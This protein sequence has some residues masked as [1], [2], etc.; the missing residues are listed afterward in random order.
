M[1]YMESLDQIASQFAAI[2]V[3]FG[4]ELGGPSA[5]VTAADL[6]ASMKPFITL[7]GLNLAALSLRHYL[8][9][10]GLS[11]VELVF[12]VLIFRFL[13]G[14]ILRRRP[15]HD[16]ILRAQ[17]REQRARAQK[18][19]QSEGENSFKS[20]DQLCHGTVFWCFGGELSEDVRKALSTL[21]VHA[22][23]TQCE[24]RKAYLEM[25]KRY[26]PD[27]FAQKPEELEQAQH[28]TL[29]IRQ[30]YDMIAKQ[31]CQAQ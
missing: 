10:I 19:P 29:K 1:S 27:R 6:V 16:Q 15:T 13:F 18:R 23:A 11:L 3:P 22:F 8:L 5:S 20:W 25:M 26:H 24:V 2:L 21:G 17:L 14:G 4:E 7:F 12:G 30:A 28:T 9:R 31:F